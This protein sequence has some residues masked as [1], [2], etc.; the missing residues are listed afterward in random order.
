MWFVADLRSKPECGHDGQCMLLWP[1]RGKQFLWRRFLEF[2][3]LV[4]LVKFFLQRRGPVQL[5]AQGGTAHQ[6]PGIGHR[7]GRYQLHPGM[8]GGVWRGH[9]GHAERVA[10]R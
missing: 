9:D 7:G 10:G 2:I 1:G 3:E 6:Q 8:L 5:H 4:Q